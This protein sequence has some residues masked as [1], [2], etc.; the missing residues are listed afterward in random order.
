[1]D[2][3]RPTADPM[4][5][6][7]LHLG[8]E[9]PPLRSF[10]AEGD[11]PRLT[12]EALAERLG[13]KNGGRRRLLGAVSTSGHLAGAR[14]RAPDPACGTQIP[15][16]VA[17]APQLTVGLGLTLQAGA[18]A[19]DRVGVMSRTKCSA[20]TSATPRNAL[21]LYARGGRP[22]SP[23]AYRPRTVWVLP[24]STASSMCAR[25][26]LRSFARQLGQTPGGASPSRRSLRRRRRRLQGSAVPQAG[27]IAR[28][29]APRDA[30]LSKQV[31]EGVVVVRATYSRRAARRAPRR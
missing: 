24:T 6:R 8:R 10:E 15:E 3:N 30:R 27:S 28:H 7:G 9:P 5:R 18:H 2:K 20:A 14:C 29:L 13:V 22:R 12:A 1:M 25:V 4:A 19:V 21:G 31:K 17:F 23:S 11:E 16:G 26:T